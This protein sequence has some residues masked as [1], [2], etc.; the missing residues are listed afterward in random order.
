MG[1]GAGPDAALEEVGVTIGGDQDSDMT[2]ATP[3]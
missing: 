2:E 3:P 1:R